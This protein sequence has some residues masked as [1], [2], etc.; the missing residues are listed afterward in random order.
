MNNKLYSYTSLTE[1]LA[2]LMQDPKWLRVKQ[3]LTLAQ[4]ISD[5]VAQQ[6]N[7]ATTADLIVLSE[8][9]VPNNDDVKLDDKVRDIQHKQPYFKKF[10][11]LN[12]ETKILNY[13]FSTSAT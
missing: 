6:D 3:G 9:V 10:N 1:T 5:R 4:S 2:S 8:R 12:H 7:A 11:R 13:Y